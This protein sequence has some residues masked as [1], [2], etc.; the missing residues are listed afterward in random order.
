MNKHLGL[1]CVLVFLPT[2]GVGIHD[3]YIAY[4]T[5]QPFRLSDIGYLIDRYAPGNLLAFQGLVGKSIMDSVFIPILKLSALPSF[6]T[7]A[8]LFYLS[9]FILK[10]LKRGPF[11]YKGDN[12]IQNKVEK[13]ANKPDFLR[14]RRRQS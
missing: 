8:G 1:I 10:S 14:F 12:P 6:A 7:L 11:R 2:L 3:G 13:D 4:I 5:S 9:L